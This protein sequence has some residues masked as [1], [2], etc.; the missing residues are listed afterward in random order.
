MENNG[1][2]N[3][4]FSTLFLSSDEICVLSQIFNFKTVVLLQTLLNKCQAPV[5]FLPPHK[6]N[7]FKFKHHST[8]STIEL[9]VI[10]RQKLKFNFPTDESYEPTLL[11]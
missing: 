11:H 2:C 3:F 7:N 6:Y 1:C 5:K 10:L 9:S 4:S 8:R